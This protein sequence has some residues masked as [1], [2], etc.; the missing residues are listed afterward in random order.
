MRDIH[1]RTVFCGLLWISSRSLL[2]FFSFCV[3]FSGPL[4]VLGTFRRPPLSLASFVHIVS[5]KQCLLYVSMLVT[6]SRNGSS[7]VVV[8][9]TRCLWRTGNAERVH[10]AS[11]SLIVP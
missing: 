11:H 8:S 5:G 1:F 7:G 2:V 6:C 3:F 9:K 10:S 4:L